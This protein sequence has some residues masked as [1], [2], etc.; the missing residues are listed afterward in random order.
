MNIDI[1]KATLCHKYGIL[2]FDNHLLDTILAPV[3]RTERKH[4]FSSVFIM[5]LL[6][7][8]NSIHTSFIFLQLYCT[9]QW[10]VNLALSLNSV[11]LSEVTS[12]GVSLVEK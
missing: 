12:N 4:P 7:K 10:A 2:V 1:L 6:E 5:P 11:Y 9:G 3:K 8:Q